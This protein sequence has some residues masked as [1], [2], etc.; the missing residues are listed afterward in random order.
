M[1][2]ASQDGEG[3][4]PLRVHELP[5]FFAGEMTFLSLPSTLWGPFSGKGLK[6]SMVLSLF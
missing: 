6:L 1:P 5:R 2:A 3:K 4:A